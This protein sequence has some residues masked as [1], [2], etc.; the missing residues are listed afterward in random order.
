MSQTVNKISG[1]GETSPSV[2]FDMQE[3]MKKELHEEAQCWV[4]VFVF[5]RMQ[6]IIFNAYDISI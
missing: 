3:M 4:S 6:L 5:V 2:N 1:D